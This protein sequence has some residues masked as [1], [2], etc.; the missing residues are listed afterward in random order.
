MNRWMIKSSRKTPHFE[1]KNNLF[2]HKKEEKK[3]R[4]D[5]YYISKSQRGTSYNEIDEEPMDILDEHQTDVNDC[6]CGRPACIKLH[7]LREE[8]P[9]CIKLHG[10]KEERPV[11]IKL[12]GLKGERLAC[13]RLH[14][15]SK[16]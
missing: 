6:Y 14:G 2:S 7:G 16:V 9:V 5:D 11:C 4:M 3:T 13:I 10:L 15:L 8:R 1:G 12:H